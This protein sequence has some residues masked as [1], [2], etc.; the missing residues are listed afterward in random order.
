MSDSLNSMVNNSE[1]MVT[2]AERMIVSPTPDSSYAS[3]S[4]NPTSP[5]MPRLEPYDR[6]PRPDGNSLDFTEFA[7]ALS[8]IS[9][10]EL[11][12][13]EN[14]D[15]S[16]VHAKQIQ[17]LTPDLHHDIKPSNI[18][19]EPN[20]PDSKDPLFED[21]KPIRISLIPEAHCP[22][23]EIPAL[24]P[25]FLSKL[26][27]KNLKKFNNHVRLLKDIIKTASPDPKDTKD[28]KTNDSAPPKEIPVPKSKSAKAR[29]RR[30]YNNNYNRFPDNKFHQSKSYTRFGPSYNRFP[31]PPSYSSAHGQSF[32]NTMPFPRPFPQGF[33]PPHGRLPTAPPHILEHLGHVSQMFR[34]LSDNF[35]K[36]AVN[37]NNLKVQLRS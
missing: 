23:N 16:P 31:N 2:N 34:N 25:E 1:R 13:N 11:L 18:K 26:T 15:L 32:N 12:L 22:P 7:D 5:K 28:V 37:F 6:S 14:L 9:N 29:Q 19:S 4:Y 20:L 27:P 10:A 17:Y 35:D 36:F 3:D 33:V 8:D 21:A 24:E 30:Q